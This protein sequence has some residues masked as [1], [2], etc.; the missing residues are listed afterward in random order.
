MHQVSLKKLLKLNCPISLI[1][2][3]RESLL[4]LVREYFPPKF[5]SSTKMC[6]N[7]MI[8][9]IYQHRKNHNPV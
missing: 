4:L 9:Q 7:K 5:K 2:V 1:L 3:S 8:I 6:T